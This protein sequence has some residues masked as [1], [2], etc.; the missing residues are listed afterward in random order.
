LLEVYERYNNPVV[1][2]EEVDR[3]RVSRY[4]VID[5]IQVEDDVYKVKD[6][7]EKPE[8]EEAPSNLVIAGRYIFTPDI[9]GYLSQTQP[10]KGMEIQVT[11]AMRMMVRD[12]A[13]YGV[14]LNG[15]RCDIGNKEGFIKTN[16]EFALKRADMSD[17][18]G[19]YIIALADEIQGQKKQD[20][21]ERK[22]G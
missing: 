14:R 12:R 11:D 1:L 18:L 2:L 21:T 20:K 16:I 3:S 15:K 8:P 6:F 19:D 5:P 7:I 10:G 22:K 13:M 17:D 4:G 9:F